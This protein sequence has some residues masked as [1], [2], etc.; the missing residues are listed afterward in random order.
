MKIVVINNGFVF[1]CGEFSQSQHHATMTKARCIRT[2]G[3]SNGLGQLAAG[4]TKETVL[5]DQ[6][7]IVE[8]PQH[9][10]VFTFDVAGVWA[11]YLK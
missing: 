8:V 4:P 9:Q 3:T 11:N 1:V 2:W 6:I 5:D 10:I 7:P